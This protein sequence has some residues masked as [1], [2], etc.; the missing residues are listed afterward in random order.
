MTGF[1]FCNTPDVVKKSSSGGA[2]SAIITAIKPMTDNK[3][4]IYGAAFDEQLNVVH[5][6][7]SADEDY[8]SLLGSKYCFSE[9][10][11]TLNSVSASLAEGK[12]VI[13]T[14]TPCQVYALKFYLNKHNV[15]QINLFTIDL[16]CHGS[17][18]A[19]Y[20]NEYKEWLE[21]RHQKKLK[22]YNFR[23]KGARWHGY[24]I[25]AEFDDGER[26]VNSH[27]LQVYMDLYFTHQVMKASCYSCK[28]ASLQRPGDIT[29]GDFWGANEV[30]PDIV[31]RS[32]SEQGVSLIIT[33]TSKGADVLCQMTNLAEDYDWLLK[34]CQDSS[35]TK[36]QT[37]LTAP[38]SKPNDNVAFHTYA[39]NN[40]FEKV[41]NKYAGFNLRG[42]VRYHIKYLANFLGIIR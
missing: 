3:I 1:L 24:S 23:Y 22:S 21:Y 13:F 26:L 32:I 17:P 5:K 18:D 36:Y 19:K 8:S 11:E 31:N 20:W 38:I 27:D 33:N 6:K 29:L 28:F 16:I 37:G 7:Y 41:I 15:N 4:V 25:M 34:K 12:Y 30:F 10:S 42:K 14:G 9:Y 40:C 39:S 2:F 35:F